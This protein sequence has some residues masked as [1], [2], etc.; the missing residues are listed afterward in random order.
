ML[1]GYNHFTLVYV[2]YHVLN[3][4][5]YKVTQYQ[6]LL[7]SSRAILDTCWH[8]DCVFTSHITKKAAHYSCHDS[9]KGRHITN[10]NSSI[11]S[12]KLHNNDT[13]VSTA[14]LFHHIQ[15][16]QNTAMHNKHNSK[17]HAHEQQIISDYI[18]K[19]VHNKID[20]TFLQRCASRNLLNKGVGKY[21]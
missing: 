8:T 10:N 7:P 6:P 5:L 14:N 15:H 19:V 2:I 18:S 16:L 9:S 20:T 3:L 21:T 12:P 1:L 17:N 13:T 4:G 11:N